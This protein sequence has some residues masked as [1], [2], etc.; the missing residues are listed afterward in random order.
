[1]TSHLRLYG[2]ALVAATWAGLRFAG[3]H[4]DVLAGSFLTLLAVSLVVA[5]QERQ[6]LVRKNRAGYRRRRDD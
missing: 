3:L 1:M 6:R 5:E 4:S 2:S